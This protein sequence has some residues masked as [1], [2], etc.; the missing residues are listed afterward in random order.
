MYTNMKISG[1]LAGK[2]KRKRKKNSGRGLSPCQLNGLPRAAKNGNES[3][4][5]S[6]RKF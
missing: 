3:I 1:M 4:I 6:S 5:I 2:D